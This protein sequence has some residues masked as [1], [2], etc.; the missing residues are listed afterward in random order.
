M[1]EKSFHLQIFAFLQP[2]KK[3]NQ[4][5]GGYSQPSHAGIQ[6]QVNFY[7]PRPLLG[8]PIQ[9]RGSS[10]VEDGRGQIIL[11]N[12]PAFFRPYAAQKQN[13]PA[14][15]SL[16]KFNTLPAIGNGK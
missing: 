8:L 5:R 11:N 2:V 4:V 6:L 14:Y 1:G 15:S 12:R 10:Q 13:G 16:S 7:S 9:S 3:R